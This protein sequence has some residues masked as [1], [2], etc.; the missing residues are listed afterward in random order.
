MRK[1][2][3]LMILFLSLLVFTIPIAHCNESDEVQEWIA[4][5]KDEDPRIRQTAAEILGRLKDPRAI[6]PLILALV[7]EASEVREAAFEALKN[8]LFWEKSDAARSLVP[9]L[10]EALRDE[11]PWARFIAA[12]SLGEIKDPRAVEPLIATLKDKDFRVRWNAAKALGEIGDPKA[13]KPLIAALKD[14]DSWVRWRAAEAL[15]EI[16][17]SKALEPL[18]EAL[19][20][21]LSRDYVAEALEEITGE[22]LGRNFWKWREWFEKKTAASAP[23]TS[24]VEFEGKGVPYVCGGGC[25]SGGRDRFGGLN[26]ISIENGRPGK[27]VRI[28]PVRG[29]LPQKLRVVLEGRR[30]WVDLGDHIDYAALGLERGDNSWS[31][32]PQ[33]IIEGTLTLGGSLTQ[34]GYKL[35]YAGGE[36]RISLA[37]DYSE[38]FKAV[39]WKGVVLRVYD[40]AGVEIGKYSFRETRI[41]SDPSSPLEAGGI[42][43]R[44][45][46]AF[47]QCVWWALWRKW[48]EEWKPDSSKVIKVG[49]GFYPPP[50]GKPIEKGWRPLP[51]DIIVLHRGPDDGHY[52]FVER[53]DD[54]E[55]RSGA[56]PYIKLSV[57][58]FNLATD[59][60]GYTQTYSASTVYWWP[61]GEEVRFTRNTQPPYR[62]Y[63]WTK[64][65]NEK[66]EWYYVGP[67]RSPVGTGPVHNPR[68]L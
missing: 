13:V 10:I 23:T 35:A 37:D 62:D 44:V 25:W 5:L 42:F 41:G 56:K 8:F 1:S 60:G 57:S 36:F 29:T 21:P 55:Y 15:G 49:S 16:K 31:K 18:I 24:R 40:E 17:D 48:E 6:G 63:P 27:S 47:G 3:F 32:T 4:E 61:D 58:E 50:G 39:P 7:D 38:A 26:E 9:K 46:S 65:T 64:K 68:V 51:H 28:F 54:E 19:K 53:V 11:N 59:S 45:E 2:G 34:N 14:E 43:P 12:W 20:D 22:K 66:W 52:A 30:W 67:E 33:T